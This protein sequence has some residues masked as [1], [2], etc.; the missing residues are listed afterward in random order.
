VRI[1]VRI[2]FALFGITALVGLFALLYD[3][4]PHYHG[5]G[6]SHWLA[7]ARSSDASADQRQEACDAIRQ[8]GPNALPDLLRWAIGHRSQTKIKIQTFIRQHPTAFIPKWLRKWADTY[9]DQ[10]RANEA[11]LAF[12]ILGPKAAPLIPELTRLATAVPP[13]PGEYW[14]ISTLGDIGPQALPALITTMDGSVRKKIA[15]LGAIRNLGTNAFPTLPRIIRLLDDPERYVTYAS[16][17]TLGDLGLNPQLSIPALIKC[18]QHSDSH[19][20]MMAALSLARFGPDAHVVI[21]ELQKAESME[22]DENAKSALQQTLRFLDAKA[23]SNTG[24]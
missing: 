4:E 12:L 6:L 17:S 3:S 22:T 24:P 23:P 8:I 11:R 16:A 14:A 9:P 7:V 5:R 21:P 10:T 18:L 15:A 2:F 13:E 20:R 19:L 1:S